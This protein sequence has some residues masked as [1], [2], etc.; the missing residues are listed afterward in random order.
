VTDPDL[1]KYR[2]MDPRTIVGAAVDK[3]AGGVDDGIRADYLD[4]YDGE[5]FADSML[6]VRAY[7]QE[8]PE[9]AQLLPRIQTP[10]TIINGRND[11]VV[12]L[13]NAEYLDERLSHSRVAVIEA[14]HMVWE[15]APDEYAAL[16]LQAITSPP[17]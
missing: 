4:C 9:L 6:Y 14:G 10:V 2:R 5:R 7:P 11:P 3:I 12:P 15:E 17:E 1:E 13:A 16:V 8:L